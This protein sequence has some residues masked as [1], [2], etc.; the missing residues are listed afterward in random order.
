MKG[1]ITGV[2]LTLQ[3]K[4]DVHDDLH[5]GKQGLI[6]CRVDAKDSACSRN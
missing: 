3:S 4:E 1:N 5:R 2:L 6:L